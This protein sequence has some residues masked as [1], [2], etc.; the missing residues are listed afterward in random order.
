MAALNYAEQYARELAQ[1]YPYV[2]NF[3]ALYATENNGR[4]RMGEDS[5]TIYIPRISTT[6]RVD[7]DRDT[8]AMATRNYD[9]SW[10][11]KTLTHQRKWSTLVHPKDI[12][13]TNQVASIA[14]I[15]KVYNEEQKFPEM[16]AYTISKL[17]ELWTSTDANDADKTA[18]TAD[19][20]E[21]TVDTVL[22][23]FDNLMLNMDEAR[24]PANGRILYVTAAVKK[25]LKNAEG[26]TRNIDVENSVSSVNRVVSR[27]DEVEIIAVPSTL[28]MTAYDFTEGWAA[29][30]GAAQINM[31]LVHP[32]AVITPVSYEFAQLDSPS[33]VTEGKYIYFEES[34]EDVFILNKKQDA[35]Q[36]N[37]TA[38]E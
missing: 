10:E 18:M 27:L 21:L 16:D 14:N 32:G 22:E 36:F 5:K 25:L 12:D 31:F 7:S 1:A 24:V 9:N 33:A 6:G 37:I 15:T 38:G 28:M 11:P 20:T 8:I 13:Q 35:L 26:L 34:Y 23:V 4:Y 3:G 17:Y 19:T 2:L 29:A 30:D